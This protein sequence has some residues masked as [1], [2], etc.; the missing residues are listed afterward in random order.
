[1]KPSSQGMSMVVRSARAVVAGESSSSTGAGTCRGTGSRSAVAGE[2]GEGHGLRA[3]PDRAT[4]PLAVIGEFQ[5]SA[6]RGELGVVTDTDQDQVPD[7]HARG[8]GDARSEGVGEGQR[9]QRVAHGGVE[10]APG[11]RGPARGVAVE[12]GATVSEEGFCAPRGVAA[13]SAGRG[14]CR[15]K[16]ATVRRTS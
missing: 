2:P 9:E 5:R 8:V 3:S 11:V 10:F 7:L 16:Y 14:L 13:A 4:Q 15:L 12:D 1:M 6:D